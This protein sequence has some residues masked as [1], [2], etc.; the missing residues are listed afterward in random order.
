MTDLA[1]QPGVIP[2]VDNHDGQRRLLVVDIPPFSANAVRHYAPFASI[3]GRQYVVSWGSVTFEIPADRNV[4]V[5]V[6]LQ[7]NYATGVTSTPFASIVLAPH[8]APVRLAMQFTTNAE[9]SLIPVG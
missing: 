3:D 8:P 7:T 9:G 1:S 6:H 4:H 5:S 2:Y